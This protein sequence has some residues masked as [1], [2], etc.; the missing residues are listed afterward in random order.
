MNEFCAGQKEL[1]LS[2]TT[3]EDKGDWAMFAGPGGGGGGGVK[4]PLGW[5]GRAG[6]GRGGGGGGG[7]GG[8]IVIPHGS[9]QLARGVQHRD[10]QWLMRHA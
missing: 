2:M 9:C 10:S 6:G 8:S 7:G 4:N 3:N 1:K 5:F